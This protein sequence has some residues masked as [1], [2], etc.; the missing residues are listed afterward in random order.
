MKQPFEKIDRISDLSKNRNYKVHGFWPTMITVDQYKN[1][2][3]GEWGKPEVNW[4]AGGRNHKEE[5]S[6][7]AAA[8]NFALALADAIE[9]AKAWEREME[10]D[11][12]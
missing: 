7:L 3:T 1:I 4:S 6:Y 5:S 8:E 12:P 9:T 10:G 2:R 11:E